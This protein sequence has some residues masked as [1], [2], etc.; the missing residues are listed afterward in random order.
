MRRIT[1]TEQLCNRKVSRFCYGFTGGSKS[2]RGF[3]ET[4][5]RTELI[6]ETIETVIYEGKCQIG[7]D[8]PKKEK[9]V[10]FKLGRL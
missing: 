2:F 10:G 9:S 8:K 5:P 7:N 1:W 6:K 4:G 3:R